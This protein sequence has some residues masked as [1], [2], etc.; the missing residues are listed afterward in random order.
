M[1]TR[2]QQDCCTDSEL[3]THNQHFTLS[4]EKVELS[5]DINVSTEYVSS[6]IFDLFYAINAV[7]DTAE[8]SGDEDKIYDTKTA[9]EDI[10]SYMKHLMRDSQQAKAKVPAFEQL[11]SSTAFWLKDYAQKVLPAKYRETQKDYFGKKGMTLHIDV[12]I[13]K[14]DKGEL[15]K[16]V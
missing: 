6:A 5:E 10:I 14:S 7:N 4:D 12:V 3:A 2:Y 13:S 16:H 1:K 11:D 15:V 9:T 8:K